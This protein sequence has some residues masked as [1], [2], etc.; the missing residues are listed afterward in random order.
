MRN[1]KQTFH[2]ALAC[3]VLGTASAEGGSASAPN[4]EIVTSVGSITVELWPAHA[5]ETVA[6]FLQLVDAGFYEGLVFHRVIP[7]FMI[8][9]GGYDAAMNY[10][11]PPRTVVNESANGQRNLRWTIA[12]ARHSDPDSADSQFF[13]N[14]IDNPHLDAQPEQPGYTVFGRVV[15]GQDV[16][17]RI[18]LTDTGT[19]AGKVNVPVTPIAIES[20]RRVPAAGADAANAEGGKP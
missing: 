10:R 19:L 3:G 11:S 14:V 7:G 2:A 17:E 4:V 15:S 9:A 8:Q 12:M 18:E 1:I 6:N 13:I 20:V 16:A 5:P